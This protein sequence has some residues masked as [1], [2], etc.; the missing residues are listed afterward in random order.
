MFVSPAITPLLGYRPEELT[1]APFSKLV[2]PDQ[3]DRARH[4]ITDRRAGPR[5][6]RRVLLELL[7]KLQPT[8]P[9]SAR[10]QAEVSAKGLYDA[11]RHYTGT[12]GLIRDMTGHLAQTETIQRLETRLLESD[13]HRAIAQRLTS[14]SHELHAPLSAMLTQSQLLLE[15]IREAQL[16]TRLE[17]LTAQAREASA[18]GNALAQA[19]VDA[20]LAEDQLGRVIAETLAPLAHLNIVQHHDTTGLSD[21]GSSRNIW[22]RI[23]QIVVI[24]AI[25]QMAARHTIHRL[26]I[27]TQTVTATGTPINPAPGLFPAPAPREVEILIQ[28]S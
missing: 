9:D 22:V 6:A 23:I 4:R 7:K 15:T 12:L 19:V 24:Q 13:R 21:V 27:F 14:L 28:E 17:S 8:G 11:R 5:A 26:D 20:G 1:G 10:V 18:C 16:D 25:R 2:P 3:L